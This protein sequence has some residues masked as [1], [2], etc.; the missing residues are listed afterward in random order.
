LTAVGQQY[1]TASTFEFDTNGVPLARGQLFFFETGTSTPQSVYAD[2]QLTTPLS[3]PVIAD[4]NGRFGAIWL[5]PSTGYK[6]QLFTAAT[7]D[8]PDGVQIWTEDPIGPAAGGAVANSA[9]II[10]EVRSFAGIAAAI[11]S[12]WYEC[13]GQAVLRSTYS[14][15]FAVLGT[16]W[17]GGDGTTTFN[18]PD[19]RGRTEFGLDNMGG[20]PASRVTAGVSGVPG[21]T[22]GGVGGDQHAQEDTL[23]ST[24]ASS[25]AVT[26]PGH[27]HT[28]LSGQATAAGSNPNNFEHG[29]VVAD[30][31]YVTDD[32][33][34]GVT[35]ATTTTTT[36]TSSLTGASQNM[37]PAAMVYKIIYAG[38]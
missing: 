24:S 20:S 37:P 7:D 17:G 8:N 29:N 5:N 11:P 32:A 16:S 33:T 28:L 10:G 36:T 3:N 15:L 18:L 23:D 35:V 1:F 4:G 26:D 38:A 13:Y 19:L 21:T 27:H 34:T 22:L 14:A 9:G 12:Q 2:P 6:V 30:H 25:S 31:S